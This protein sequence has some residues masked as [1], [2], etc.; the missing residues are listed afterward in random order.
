MFFISNSPLLR[1][2]P[3]LC[4]VAGT[5]CAPAVLA[6][7]PDRPLKLIVPYPRGGATDVIGRIL[8]RLSQEVA[9]WAKLIADVNIKADE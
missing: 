5:F 8:A 7:Y 9:R 4:L 3:G 2:F 1:A 6:A